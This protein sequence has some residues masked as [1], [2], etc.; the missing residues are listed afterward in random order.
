[1]DDSVAGYKLRKR[2]ELDEAA[3][4]TR[5]EALSLARRLAT[6][7][8]AYQAA[9]AAY[10]EIEKATCRAIDAAEVNAEV[11]AE[12]RGVPNPSPMFPMVVGRFHMAKGSNAE[13]IKVVRVN[14]LVVEDNDG[15]E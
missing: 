15:S 6:A 14:T 4:R 7:Y 3:E 11:A 9:A 13:T 12:E 1:M 8:V 10:H 5:R 2:M